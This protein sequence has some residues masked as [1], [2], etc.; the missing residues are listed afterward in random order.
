MNLKMQMKKIKPV[1]T[2]KAILD[3]L[4]GLQPKRIP[5]WLMR[6]AGRYLPEYRE[7]RS[8]KGG[9]LELAMDPVAAC[10][11]TLQPLRRFEMDAAIIFS[12]ILIVPMAMGMDLQFAEGEGPKLNAL[13]NT[14]DIEK[15]NSID[16][17]KIV[18]VFEAIERVRTQMKIENLHETALIGFAGAPWTVATY[19]IEGGSSK[20]FMKTKIMAYTNPEGFAALIEKLVSATSAYLIQQI[21]AGAEILQIFDSWAGV[22]DEE[23][24]ENFAIK[25]TREIV[26][27][28]RK[29][30]PEIPIIGFPKGAGLN[31]PAYAAQTGITAIGLDAQIS[32]TW[33]AQ[34]LQNLMPVQG[35]MDPALLLAGGVAM[36]KAARKIIDELR[37]G[38]FIFNLGHGIHKDTPP[39][40]VAALVG[41][42]RDF[43][44]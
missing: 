19:M 38:G 10:E 3:V 34:N 18:P 23:R 44:N 35:N 20:D 11:I 26:K 42:I 27:N 13:K 32:P 28:I 5:F 7:L 29:I 17:Q 37:G 21:K 39:E 4:G 1:S 31:Y 25:P 16:L 14:A 41:I 24:F 36:E 2:G 40:N 43:K 9:F 6:Q 12:D 15:L 30:Y 33:A 8:Q 22:L